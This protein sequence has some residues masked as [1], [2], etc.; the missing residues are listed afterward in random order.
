MT[1]P[2]SWDI[3]SGASATYYAMVEN[4]KMKN[5]MKIHVL[6]KDLKFGYAIPLNAMAV[7]MRKTSFAMPDK[8]IWTDLE[9]NEIH[10]YEKPVPWSTIYLW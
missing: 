8:N 1:S 3:L 6:V 7:E 4:A 2:C 5:S 10:I 9:K